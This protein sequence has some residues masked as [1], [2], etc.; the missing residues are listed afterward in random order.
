[1]EDNEGEHSTD[2]LITGGTMHVKMATLAD[3]AM[4]T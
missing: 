3:F 4:C 2:T 1:M